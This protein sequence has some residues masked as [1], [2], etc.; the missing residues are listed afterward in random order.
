M[1][2]LFFL[3]ALLLLS[4]LS[5]AALAEDVSTYA[6]ASAPADGSHV[7]TVGNPST[8][9]VIAGQV[10]KAEIT[11]GTPGAHYN[12]Q[13]DFDITEAGCPADYS[14]GGTIHISFIGTA[15]LDDTGSWRPQR[16]MSPSW[17]V[18]Y[19]Y[20]GTTFPNHQTNASSDLDDGVKP[21]VFSN[22]TSNWTLGLS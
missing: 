3:P 6:A 21:E 20:I 19:Q 2:W 9:V 22:H 5:T 11:N 18:F 16:S 12:A 14:T 7:S 17:Q 8:N 13:Y 1:K 4:V 10:F 15:T